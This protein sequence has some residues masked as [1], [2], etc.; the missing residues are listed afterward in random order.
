MLY[1]GLYMYTDRLPMKVSATKRLATVLYRESGSQSIGQFSIV[2]ISSC[3]VT[4]DED[5]I[6]NTVSVDHA[7]LAP[8]LITVQDII[9]N[10]NNGNK[11]KY[12][13]DATK[14]NVH[15]IKISRQNVIYENEEDVATIKYASETSQ[16][17]VGGKNPS[18]G[19]KDWKRVHR[20]STYSN[21]MDS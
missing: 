13:Q 14:K 18:G 17:R 12:W 3:T 9:D 21:R 20:D 10:A 6:W 1:T 5:G 15:T 2:K 8:T 4:I 19:R 16:R 7:T 11:D